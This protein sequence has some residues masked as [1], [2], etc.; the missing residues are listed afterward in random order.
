MK[1][2]PVIQEET[3]QSNFKIGQ[4][5]WRRQDA[6]G[7]N[8]RARWGRQGGE[9]KLGKRT[10][11]ERWFEDDDGASMVK[12]ICQKKARKQWPDGIAMIVKSRWWKQEGT[13]QIMETLIMK[14]RRFSHTLSFQLNSSYPLPSPH[15][16]QLLQALGYF[17]YGYHCPPENQLP[18]GY[19]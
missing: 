9:G 2:I 7:Q 12:A 11:E 17:L 10:G 4:A 18:A 6:G 16:S 1:L 15:P 13:G 8:G 5:R 3:K 19:Q 14:R